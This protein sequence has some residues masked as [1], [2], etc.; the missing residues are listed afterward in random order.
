[1][2]DGKLSP[3]E[4]DDGAVFPL[5]NKG[6]VHVKQSGGYV[7]IAFEYLA[8]DDFVV[9]LYL[10]PA[11]GE[12]YDLHSSAK[13]GERRLNGGTWS[14]EWT[15][16]NNDGWVANCSRVES[17]E[18]GRFLPQKVREYQVSRGRFPGQTWRVM[19]ELRFPA[20]PGW[21]SSTFPEAAKNTS[22][23]HW[24]TLQF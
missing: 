12:L 10:Q 11:D 2:V 7:W 19:F 16:W 15:W 9:D 6:R 14:D 24:L 4:W 20:K 17:F 3:G 23:E 18:E 8:G 13:I 21:L 1:M 5:G 22:T